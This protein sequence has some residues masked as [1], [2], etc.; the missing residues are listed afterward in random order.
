MSYIKTVEIFKLSW[1]KFYS[2][3][4]QQNKEREGGWNR[5]HEYIGQE[6]LHVTRRLT[7][8]LI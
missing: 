3:F 7:I 6:K 2:F 8:S 1:L 5:P 4:L